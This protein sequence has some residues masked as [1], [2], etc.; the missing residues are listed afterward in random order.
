ML[1]PNWFDDHIYEY[2]ELCGRLDESIIKDVVR[3]I[4]RMGKVSD[5][6][7]WQLQKL[8]ES[9]LLY[10]DILKQI[11]R[12][13]GTSERN[14]KTL[15]EDAGIEALRWDDEIYEA[16]GLSP[17]PLRQSPVLLNLLEA[18]M[19]KT[20]GLVHNLT[21]TTAQAWQN[22]FISA[23]DLAYMQVSSGAFDYRTAI[24]NAVKSAV[25][26]STEVL[27][28]TGHRDKLDVAMRR[29]VL[30]GVNQTMGTLQ[31]TRAEEMG[32]DLVETTAHLGARPSHAEWQGKVFSR[33]GNHSKYPPFE[34]STGYG[35]GA[36]L[37][38]WNCRHSFMPFIEGASRPA[39]SK[40]YL[41]DVN[42]RKATYNGKNIPYYDAT[43]IQRGM[44]RKIR[45]TR[46]KLAGFDEAA[47]RGADV[48]SE[49]EK[50]SVKLKQ[51]E[52]ALKDFCRQTG[53]YR[54]T[55]R[56]QVLGFDKSVS[57][58]A[59]RQAEQ[60]YQNWIKE[61]GAK[62]SAPKTLA[63]YYQEKDN[64]TPAYVLL[65]GYN[66]AVK[67][68]DISPL[69]GLEQYQKTAIQIEKELVGLTLTNG[70][71]VSSY[72]THFIDRVIGQTADAHKEGMR[73]GVPVP[74]VKECLL[75]SKNISLLYQI[76]MPDGSI[77]TRINITWEKCSVAFSTRDHKIIQTN[78]L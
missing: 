59:V 75:N 62:N 10:D 72:T 1:P 8:Q 30:T 78:P 69:V 11:A 36:G 50:E 44:E 60:H 64:N 22:A 63:K 20:N 16:A 68:G 38:G 57:Q 7:R 45:D 47:K 26:Q 46:R 37:C 24:R 13:S 19:R 18:G 6:S 35:T 49:F 29:A 3:R 61:I 41:D 39:Y 54:N 76:K 48:K 23:C 71:K 34:S 2:L 77:D 67:K 53:L 21:M 32:C 74:V 9:G 70:E 55:N 58:K 65:Q 25:D 73:T 52:A 66:W 12:F 14:V 17:P 31:L 51:Q 40:Q 15:F 42:H 43:Q 4:C 33:S 56:F 28:P 5:A 27:Y